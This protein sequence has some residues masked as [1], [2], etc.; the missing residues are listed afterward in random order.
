MG[1][2]SAATEQ[3]GLC[4]KINKT[5]L[6]WAILAVIMGCL[7]VWSVAHAQSIKPYVQTTNRELDQPILDSGKAPES[8]ASPVRVQDSSH[9]I[10]A[11]NQITEE[12]L[13][14]YLETKNSPLADFSGQVLSSPYW[15]T[16]IAICTI[17]EYSCSVNPYGSNNLWGLMSHGK[18]IRYNSLSDGIDAIASFLE[19]AETTGRTTIES[20]NC[21]YVQ[22]CSSN[23]E[24]TVI[25]TKEKLEAL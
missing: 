14:Q 18:L 11:N 13:R 16:I 23:W 22:P 4:I 3:N 1:A 8:P 10:R 7:C 6:I 9:S 20:L 21:W 5:T 2:E 24:S 19:R 12:A 17:E 15:S 25:S